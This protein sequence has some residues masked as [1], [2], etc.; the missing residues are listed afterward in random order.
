MFQAAPYQLTLLLQHPSL[1]TTEFDKILMFF[2]MGSV[3]TE[4]LRK[5]FQHKFP[6]HPLIIVYGMTEACISISATGPND[7]IAGLTVG[8]ILHNVKV[9]I[10]GKND[11]PVD[12]GVTGEIYAKPEFPFLGYYNNSEA[13]KSAIDEEG[14]LKTG[15]VG[16]VDDS[17]NIFLIDRKKDV[18]KYKGYQVNTLEIESLIESIEGV[19]HVSVVGIPDPIC[20]NLPA[21]VV[22]KREGF[23]DLNEQY[24]VDFVG[25]KLPEYNQLHGGV[26]FVDDLP[27][28]PSGKIQKRFVKVIAIREYELKNNQVDMN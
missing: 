24:I 8:K 9:K 7:S 1:D 2:A 14:Y 5:Q 4:N 15:D 11:K 19:E 10:V 16:F 17:G 6:K 21:A 25:E 3:V 28:T 23:D 22:V 26:Y 20:T 27:M 13:S 18:I 12:V